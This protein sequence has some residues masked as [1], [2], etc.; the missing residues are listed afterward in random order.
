MKKNFAQQLLLLCGTGYFLLFPVA[1]LSGQSVGRQCISSYGS[2]I[3][4]E[5]GVYGQTAG[6]AY[7][8]TVNYS[9]SP[10]VLH[11]FQQPSFYISGEESLREIRFKAFPVPAN[12]FITLQSESLE[13]NVTVVVSDFAGKVLFREDVAEMLTYNIDCSNWVNGLFLV[14]IS[15]PGIRSKT[16]KVIV[17]K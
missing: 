12:Q 5:S 3:S 1:R 8:T 2:G 6:Q 11:G 14:T 13:K 16:I 15:N 9:E 7:G 10:V 4:A 17:S